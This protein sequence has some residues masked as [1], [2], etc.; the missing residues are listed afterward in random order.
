MKQF[1]GFEDSNHILQMHTYPER[2]IF[3]MRYI[4]KRN[5]TL[6]QNYSIYNIHLSTPCSAL[7]VRD[8]QFVPGLFR[9]R[10]TLLASNATH[11]TGVH[12]QSH[13]SFCINQN[14]KKERKKKEETRRR[15]KKKKQKRRPDKH[16]QPDR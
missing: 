1:F 11:S 14:E 4:Y 12:V 9:M 15:R 6:D 7:A 16:D 8:E 5:N 10:Y 3:H 13:A 2:Q